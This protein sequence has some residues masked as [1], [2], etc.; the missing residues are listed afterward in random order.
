MECLLLFRF[1]LLLLF[2][3]QAQSMYGCMQGISLHSWQQRLAVPL[4]KSYV[5]T[6]GTYNLTKPELIY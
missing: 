5:L 4:L 2:K 3:T 6:Q 1:K